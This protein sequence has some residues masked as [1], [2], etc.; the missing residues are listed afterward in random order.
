MNI[1]RITGQLAS[2][3]VRR[4]A[5][6]EPA[7]IEEATRL[8]EK[9]LNDLLQSASTTQFGRDHDFDS[10]DGVDAFQAAVPI[11]NYDQFWQ[12]YWSK[13]FPVLENVTWPGNIQY[14][15]K[16]SGTTSSV[17]K[18]IP[19]T[20]EMVKANNTAGSQVLIEHFR[21]K[22]D[23]KALLGRYFMFAG[24]PNLEEIAPG[25]F[26]GELSGIAARERPSWAGRDRYYPPDDLAAITNWEE[27]LETISEDCLDKDIRAISG[28]PSWLQILFQRIFDESVDH[29]VYLKDYFSHLEL[30]VHGG[31]SFEPYRQKFN[32][33]VEG[34]DVDFREIYA[35]SEGFFAIA[36][37]R[38]DDGMRLIIDNG[39]FYEF[40]PLD[41]FNEE[42]PTRLWIEDIEPDVDYVLVVSTCAGLWSYVVGDII[43]FVDVDKLNLKFSGRLSQTLSLFGE[44]LLNDVVDRAVT[45]AARL[46][47][48]GINDFAVAP[49]M[50]EQD[51]KGKYVFLVEASDQ[52]SGERCSEFAKRVDDDLRQSN[53]G[54]ATRRE[55]SVG[56]IAPDVISVR[57]GTFAKWMALR[58]RSGGQNKVPRTL[59]EEQ[60]E[61]ILSI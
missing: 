56:M 28:V 46:L 35:A 17:S 9:V 36:S 27:K 59:T 14:F 55:N 49:V 23:S 12:E 31:M 16:T 50:D 37:G 20:A 24:S 10:I 19:C 30:L 34:I 32:A 6:R 22:P 13:D 11:R 43:R 42:N 51:Q 54:Y 53:S 58:G 1:T 26:A 29:S 2:A 38:P 25:I 5:R 61:D 21:N 52:M 47:G 60:M 44:K 40:I 45:D 8:Q 57:V 39:I 15:A 48:V 18:F 41:E 33:M 7:R 3:I 4:M